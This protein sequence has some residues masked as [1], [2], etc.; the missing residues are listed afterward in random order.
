MS[1]VVQSVAAL[2]ACGSRLCP[3]VYYFPSP[4]HLFGRS[5]FALLHF[6]Q[7]RGLSLYSGPSFFPVNFA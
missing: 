2:A 4:S 7:T 1:E 6:G 3:V 5:Q